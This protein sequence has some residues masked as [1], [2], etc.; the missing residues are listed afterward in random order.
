MTKVSDILKP[1]SSEEI[2]QD[3]NKLNPVDRF[4]AEFRFQYNKLIVKNL[5]TVDFIINGISNKEEVNYLIIGPTKKRDIISEEL[6]EFLTTI[7]VTDRKN[8]TLC[9]EINIWF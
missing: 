9:K 7:Y 1:K 5:R 3:L 6:P 2:S 8:L 4:C